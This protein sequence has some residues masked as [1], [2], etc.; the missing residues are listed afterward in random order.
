MV[1]I[2]QR[3]RFDVGQRQVGDWLSRCLLRHAVIQT[4]ARTD[5]Q[6]GAQQQHRLFIQ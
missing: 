2:N 3:H 4:G 5:Q 6:A 1:L